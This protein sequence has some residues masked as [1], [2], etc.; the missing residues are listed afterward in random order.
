MTSGPFIQTH[1]GWAHLEL[2][3]LEAQ[4]INGDPAALAL[5][6]K[7]SGLMGWPLRPW[8]VT[9][10]AE[11]CTAAFSV[12]VSGWDA[13][14]LH[15]DDRIKTP[16][17]L[18]K[19]RK[20]VADYERLCELLRREPPTAINEDFFDDIAKKLGL[21]FSQAKNLYYAVDARFRPRSKR[22]RARISSRKHAAK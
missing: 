18:A 22:S 11:A 14:L 19:A 4:F 3:R 1:A 9:A 12:Q 5:A 10:W 21:T 15:P 8:S 7:V 16:R 13:V 17:Q 2:A 20:K 6:I